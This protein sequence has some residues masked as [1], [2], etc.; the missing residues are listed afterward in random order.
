[1]SG[2]ESYTVTVP[3]YGFIEIDVEGVSS[4][5]EAEEKAMEDCMNLRADTS[6]LELG[7]HSYIELLPYEKI[8]EGNTA[9]V[10]V[11]QITSKPI[12]D[13]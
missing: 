3:V 10:P 4:Q 12:E 5:Q 2:N 1:M 13:D 11:S 8:L 7:K 9:F 6:E